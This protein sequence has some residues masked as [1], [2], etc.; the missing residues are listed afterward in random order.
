MNIMQDKELKFICPENEDGVYHGYHD[1]EWIGGG[2]YKGHY[3]KGV[4]Y[5]YFQ[6]VWCKGGDLILEYHAR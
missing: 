1:V 3:I 5:G 6:I 4:E 2:W